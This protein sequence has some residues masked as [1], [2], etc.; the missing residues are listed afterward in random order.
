MHRPGI[1]GVL[2]VTPDSFSDGGRWV[3]VEQAVGHAM[4]MVAAGADVIDVGG[5]S[6]RPGASRVPPAVQRQR[7]TAGIEAL[8]RRL[9]RRGEQP[10]SG[11]Q[12]PA[13]T[14]HTAKAPAAVHI[15]IDTTRAE[16]A[17]AAIDAGAT[18]INDVSAGRDDP[19]MLKLAARRG[20]WLVLMH[21]QGQP[22]KM[23]LNPAYRDVVAE[24]RSFLLERALAA[25]SAGVQR[26]RIW[27]D[28]GIGFGKT[29]EHNLALLAHLD[30][31]VETGYPILVGASRKRF[32]GAIIGEETAAP[33]GNGINDAGQRVH[34]TAATTAVA[35][36]AGARMCRVH[37]VAPNRHAA[38]VAWAIR[39][40]RMGVG[41]ARDVRQTS[42][43]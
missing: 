32:L 7:T 11:A 13:R 14:G 22:D 19:R 28:P 17:E 18:F 16:V 2:N 10:P 26:S 29:I 37:D 9:R 43:K 4:A 38:D 15:S 39:T 3:D 12:A 5:E 41:T 30:Q 35:V 20:V 40:A 23:Q 21:M 34:A 25:E 42:G 36:M 24:V 8:A 31:L 27:L 33:S 6:T 1:M